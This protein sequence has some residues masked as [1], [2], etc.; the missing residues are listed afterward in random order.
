MT[1]PAGPSSPTP[2]AGPGRADDVVPLDPESPKGREVAARLSAV[3]AELEL[4]LAAA[5]V[6][7]PQT[8]AA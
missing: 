2:P 8:R 3:I 6:I 7:A 4:E 5:A 1:S